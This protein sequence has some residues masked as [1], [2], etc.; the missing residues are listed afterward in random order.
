MAITINGSGTITGVFAYVHCRPDGSVFYVGKGTH[1][2]MRLFAQRNKYH[3]N[4][5]K[6]Y[7]RDNILMG[8]LECSSNEIAF[9]L[10]RGLIKCLKRM[11]ANLT[12]MSDGGEGI[13]AGNLPWN[14][15][16]ELTDEH[17]EKCRVANSGE[18]NPFYGKHHSAE[19]KKRMSI[20]KKGNTPA[21]KG[22]KAA[23]IDCPHCGKN[24]DVSNAK[25]WHM[26]NCKELKQ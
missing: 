13:E 25:R 2:R 15:G 5:V 9:D 3:K 11:G 16:K 19:T 22:M 12:N 14:T 18:N 1:K 4:V 26:D 17:K 8:K 23:R 10:E 6:K 21:N 24:I 20:A 7:G